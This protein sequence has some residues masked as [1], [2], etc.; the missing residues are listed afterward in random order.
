MIRYWDH[1]DKER[2]GF[3]GDDIHKFLVVELMEKGIVKVKAPELEDVEDITIPTTQYYGIERSGGYSHQDMGLAFASVSD[4]EAFLAFGVRAI[5]R[6]YGTAGKTEHAIPLRDPRIVPK[7]L[8]SEG[9]VLDNKE[10]CERAD[11]TIERNKEKSKEYNTSLKAASEASEDMWSDWQRCCGL[12]CKYKEINA[13]FDEYLG[14]CDGNEESATVF[15]LKAYDE[16]TV[17]EARSW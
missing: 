8:P 12:D 1:S 9:A 5:D 10:A 14:I 15:L 6:G 13:T 16:D 2:A 3:S 11:A 17:K 7:M 4:A